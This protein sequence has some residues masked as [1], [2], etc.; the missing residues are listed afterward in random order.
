MS[1]RARLA[2]VRR[3]AKRSQMPTTPAICRS[4]RRSPSPCPTTRALRSSSSASCW[5]T[6]RPSQ[7]SMR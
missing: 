1:A 7:R 5:R 3:C 6:L 2:H 4:S